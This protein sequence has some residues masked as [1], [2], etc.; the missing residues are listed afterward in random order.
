MTVHVVKVHDLLDGS[1]KAPGTKVL[2]DRIWPRG[3]SK[4]DLGHDEWLKAAAPSKGL[5]TWF[6]HNPEKFEEFTR[7][8]RA[9][10]DA[11]CTDTE[12]QDD[13]REDVARL[14]KLAGDGDVSLLYAAH[15]REH[16]HAVVLADWIRDHA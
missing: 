13:A 11:A 14:L 10:L 15:D 1:A 7:R 4:E 2:V 9:E 3:V 5:R 8:Y 6:D 12:T 16:N